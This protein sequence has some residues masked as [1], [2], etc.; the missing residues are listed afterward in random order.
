MT[1]FTEDP[2]ALEFVAGQDWLRDQHEEEK[3]MPY[4]GYLPAPTMH[5]LGESGDSRFSF[6]DRTGVPLPLRR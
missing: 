5:Q 4:S 1:Q 3:G 2:E 6:S